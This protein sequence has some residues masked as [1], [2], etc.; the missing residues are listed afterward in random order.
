MVEFY[1]RVSGIFS[2]CTMCKINWFKQ[3]VW[4]MLDVH[5]G[6]LCREVM[7]FY[8]TGMKW[9]AWII[10]NELNNLR[11]GVL[12]A[13]TENTERLFSSGPVILCRMFRLCSTTWWWT[14]REKGRDGRNKT[15]G[16]KVRRRRKLT[17]QREEGWNGENEKKERR[18]GDEGKSSFSLSV[19]SSLCH[20]SKHE[21]KNRNCTKRKRK[22]PQSHKQHPD[23]KWRSPGWKAS[24][25]SAAGHM[26]GAL[27]RTIRLYLFFFPSCPLCSALPGA[28]QERNCDCVFLLRVCQKTQTDGEADCCVS[29]S[30]FPK[31]NLKPSSCAALPS[32]P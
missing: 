5:V 1:T 15:E 11:G 31:R 20:D 17:E 30:H 25:G 6:Q 23:S 14:E 32:L 13:H 9:P 16:M 4:C 28:R 18:W 21:S 27:Q 8:L 7:V 24:E 29:I 12:S 26:C 2:G 10:F 22:R 3:L 19:L